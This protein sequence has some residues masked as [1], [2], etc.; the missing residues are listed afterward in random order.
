MEKNPLILV[1]FLFFSTLFCSGQKISIPSVIDKISGDSIFYD[2]EQLQ[3]MNRLAPDN[4]R[5]CTN[6]ITEKISRYSP[7]TLFIQEF[8]AEYDLSNNLKRGLPNIIAVRKGSL[9]PDSVMVMGAHY[10]AAFVP[11]STP[12][13]FI[14]GPG[15]DDNASGTSGV[16]EI[17]R[18]TKDIDFH[19]TMVFILFSG[20]EFGLHGS[21][22][23]VENRP[24]GME[25]VYAMLNFD[26]ISHDSNNGNYTVMIV[27]KNASLPL[28]HKCILAMEKHVPGLKY[29]ELTTD[30]AFSDHASFFRAGIPAIALKEGSTSDEDFNPYYHS[31][32][33]T[34]GPS[35]NSPQLAEL[36]TKAGLATLLEIDRNGNLANVGL[37]STERLLSVYPNPVFDVVTI[38]NF[39]EDGRKRKIQL[40]NSFGHLLQIAKTRENKTQLD[41]TPYPKG[42]Y[43]LVAGNQCF[44]IIK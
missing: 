43:F 31:L 1:V 21:E 27:K 5:E 15:A 30:D 13:N 39:S 23:F 33:D 12:F 37:A 10:D 34:I 28:A 14:F 25:N 8:S 7:D 20:E 2:I 24:E 41:F 32:G 40:Y 44:K 18:V 36:I 6:Y 29:D 19:K 17:I 35:A 4:D 3:G 22:H 16:M 11:G 42:I 9:Y 26:M 38:E